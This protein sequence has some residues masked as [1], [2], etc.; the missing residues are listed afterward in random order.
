MTF[1]TN[2]IAGI[3]KKYN[4]HPNI[5]TSFFAGPFIGKEYI[6]PNKKKIFYPGNL[7]LG[8]ESQEDIKYSVNRIETIS[9]VHTWYK[10]FLEERENIEFVKP[11]LWDRF[12][13]FP[14]NAFFKYKLP[15]KFLWHNATTS[16]FQICF[17]IGCKNIAIIGIDGYKLETNNNH[18]SNYSGAEISTKEKKIR[19]NRSIIKLQ[20]A[21]SYYASKNDI[22]MHNL[23]KGSIIDHYQK[24][25]LEDFLKII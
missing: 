12:K 17:Y 18:F 3:C 15:K 23:S 19:A 16:L 8:L 14:K 25:T 9:F 1:A 6:T 22:R 21:V 4:W 2:R 24:H 7:E 20:D 11:I 5:Y 10:L 13:D